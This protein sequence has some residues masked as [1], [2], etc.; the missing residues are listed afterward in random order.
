MHD[1]PGP[2]AAA[3]LRRGGA[4]AAAA[5]LGPREPGG[6]VPARR[7][8]GRPGLPERPAAGRRAHHQR[9]LRPGRDRVERTG[10]PAADPGR[11]DRRAARAA[12]RGRRAA[13]LPAGRSLSRQL[14]RPVLRGAFPRRGEG[15]A[16][17][18]ARARGLQRLHARRI[19]RAVAGVRSRRGAPGR[20]ARRAHRVLPG[21]A[22]PGAGRLAR[23]D[24]GTAHR[25][26]RQP[27]MAADRLPGGGERR[28]AR[29]GDAPGRAAP[30]CR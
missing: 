11:G 20:A 10:Q 24:P 8:H 15:L 12:Q 9:G 2:A 30:T 1:Q 13:A 5:P 18:G 3:V 7:R 14:L 19:G 17:D 26:A 28:A 23:G 25:A 16:P 29:R 22:R 27:G 4:Q 21:L 6:G